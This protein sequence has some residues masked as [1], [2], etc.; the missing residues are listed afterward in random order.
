MITQIN[1]YQSNISYQGAKIKSPKHVVQ[2]FKKTI[3]KYDLKNKITDTFTKVKSEFENMDE[4]TK[5]LLFKVI[6]GFT[7]LG[8]FI[9][10]TIHY[11]SKIMDNINNLFQ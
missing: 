6:V 10:V 1:N 11:I 9:G 5:D 3:Q 8:T 7:L 2:N 4:E